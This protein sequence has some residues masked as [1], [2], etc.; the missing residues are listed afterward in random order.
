MNA[1]SLL[2]NDDSSPA[3][4]VS[5]ADANGASK[6]FTVTVPVTF[7]LLGAPGWRKSRIA[8]GYHAATLTVD[9]KEVG[10]IVSVPDGRVAFHVKVPG[11]KDGDS[12]ATFMSMDL[13]AQ[14]SAL[15]EAVSAGLPAQN[16][17]P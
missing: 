6:P 12:S 9:G 13:T 5:V 8:V 1:Q 3:P 2:H 16:P 10:S 14:F 4:S 17:Q 11:A 7:E 15:L